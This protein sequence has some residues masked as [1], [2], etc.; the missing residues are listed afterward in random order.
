[1]KRDDVKRGS[2]T[3]RASRGSKGRGLK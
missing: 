3:V 2:R 1:V